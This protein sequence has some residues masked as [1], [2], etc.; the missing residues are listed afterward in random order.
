M[1]LGRGVG[2]PVTVE[3]TAGKSNRRFASFLKSVQS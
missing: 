1:D 2:D 3:I